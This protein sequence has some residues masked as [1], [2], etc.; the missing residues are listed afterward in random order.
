MR[1]EGRGKKEW[2]REREKGREKKVSFCGEVVFDFS[3]VLF[4]VLLSLEIDEVWLEARE[5]RAG[6]VDFAV[7]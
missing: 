2:K 6:G 5:P 1:D 4:L 7:W 3:A